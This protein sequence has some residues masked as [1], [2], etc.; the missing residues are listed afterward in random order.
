MSLEQDARDFLSHLELERGYSPNTVRAYRADLANLCAFAAAAG[1]ANGAGGT[2]AAGETDGAGEGYGGGGHSLTLGFLRD[3]LWA[4]SNQGLSKA[5][6]ARRSA[7][8][9]SFSAWLSRTQRQSG[10]AGVR[11]RA[12]RP[13]RSLPRVLSRASMQSIFDVL[14]QRAQDGDPI[15]QRDRAIV[16]LLYASALRVSEIVGI[17]LDD[18]DVERRTVLVMGKGS[19]ERVVPFGAPALAAIIEY[20]DLGRRE[21]LVHTAPRE[22]SQVRVSAALFLNSRGARLGTRSVYSIVSEVLAGVPGSGPAGPHAFRHTAATHLLDGGADLRA[23]QEMLGHSSL[24]TTQIY[25]H[26]TTER[27]RAT[28]LGA[29]PRA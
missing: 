5:T 3:W 26:V 24:G 19:K 28:Y 17:D 4:A 8:A 10:D 18:L 27:L 14:E 7:T 12:P 16:E 13:E 20:R 15:A 21:L 25:T 23:V 6:L 9:K 11:L 29:H 1:G 22:A 2:E